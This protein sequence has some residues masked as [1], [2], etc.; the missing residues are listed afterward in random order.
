MKSAFLSDLDFRDLNYESPEGKIR[1][2]LL[3]VLRY[4][5]ERLGRIVEVPARFVT[6]LGSVPQIAW[7][8]VPPIGKADGGYVLHDWLYQQGGVT[9]GEADA[10]LYEAMRVAGVSRVLAWTIWSGVRVGGWVGWR[11][12]RKREVIEVAA[13]TEARLAAAGLPPEAA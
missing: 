2:M 11:E 3:A 1:L 13:K 5:S 4:A 7:S 8:L 9:R 6:D 10:V 12:Y